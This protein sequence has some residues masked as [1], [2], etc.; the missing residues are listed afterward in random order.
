MLPPTFW[1][2]CEFLVQKPLIIFE[3]DA[4]FSKLLTQART[5]LPIWGTMLNWAD[6][7]SAFLFGVQR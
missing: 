7:V 2:T 6:K 1:S 3:F 5:V 4:V